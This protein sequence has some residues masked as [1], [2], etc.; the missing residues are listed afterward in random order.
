[1]LIKSKLY[2]AMIFIL[3]ILDIALISN[4]N[5]ITNPIGF[6]LIYFIIFVCYMMVILGFTLRKK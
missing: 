1:M 6:R 4:N 5:F 3:M 2:I